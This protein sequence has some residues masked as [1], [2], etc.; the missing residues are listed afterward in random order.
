MVI[1]TETDLFYSMAKAN[2]DMY[3][4]RKFD[5]DTWQHCIH[6][7]VVGHCSYVS[8]LLD[9]QVMTYL[10]G[11]IHAKGSQRLVIRPLAYQCSRAGFCY[12]LWLSV[13][14]KDVGRGQ[15]GRICT[16]LQVLTHSC[17][18]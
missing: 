16:V 7:K 12:C 11:G 2:H 14:C 18:I 5:I 9:L 17:C 8:S 15:G 13:D 3:Y 1:W 10:L 4:T 6:S